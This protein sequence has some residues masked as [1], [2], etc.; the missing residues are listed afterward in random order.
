MQ[1]HQNH[2][3][4]T[5]FFEGRVFDAEYE[6][7]WERW[8]NIWANQK[9]MVIKSLKNLPAAYSWQN[10]PFPLELVNNYI[11]LFFV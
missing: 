8:A 1:W 5:S 4:K 11:T 3:V 6:Q 9:N 2:I 10:F 7:I